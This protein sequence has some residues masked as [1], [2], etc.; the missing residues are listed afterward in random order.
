MLSQII[1]YFDLKRTYRGAAVAM[2]AGARLWV[3]PQY[4]FFVFGIFVQPYLAKYQVGETIDLD[5]T[6]FWHQALFSGVVG[7]MVFPAAYK[8]LNKTAAIG[9]LELCTI[10]SSG[11][12]WQTLLATGQKA[13]LGG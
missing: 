6:R 8:S 12:T 2:V 13:A 7:L 9:F 10:F 1:G 11:V 5:F 4:F 3:I